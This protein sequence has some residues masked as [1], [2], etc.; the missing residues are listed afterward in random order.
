MVMHF[1]PIP[2]LQGLF[3]RGGGAWDPPP[4]AIH[5]FRFPAFLG[6]KV[7]SPQA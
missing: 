2:I 3:L 4:Q 5:I 1:N 7:L 6:L